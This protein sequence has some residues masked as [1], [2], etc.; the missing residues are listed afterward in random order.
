MDKKLKSFCD[1]LEKKS[2]IPYCCSPMEHENG[3]IVEDPLFDRKNFVYFNNGYF[4]IWMQSTDHKDNLPICFKTASSM[5]DFILN[6]GI[7]YL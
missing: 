2:L 4:R 7:S 3:V 6:N 1:L 5:V